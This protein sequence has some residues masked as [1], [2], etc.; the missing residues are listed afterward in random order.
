[1]INPSCPIVKDMQVDLEISDAES[2]SSELVGA[3]RSITEITAAFCFVVS[4]ATVSIELS[5]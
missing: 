1:M 3:N 2:V 4:K 5:C